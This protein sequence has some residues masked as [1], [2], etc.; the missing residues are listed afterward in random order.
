MQITISLRFVRF[1]VSFFFYSPTQ[2]NIIHL[3]CNALQCYINTKIVIRIKIIKESELTDYEPKKSD[4]RNYY[5]ETI[6][7][8]LLRTIYNQGGGIINN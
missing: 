4:Y 5:C 1:G 3:K 2:I 6:K 8:K 7:N